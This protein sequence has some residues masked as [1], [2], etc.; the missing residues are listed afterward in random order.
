MIAHLKDLTTVRNMINEATANNKGAPYGAYLTTEFTGQEYKFVMVA[1][2]AGQ[3]HKLSS[4]CTT[5]ERL[6]AHWQ[7]FLQNLKD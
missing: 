1:R 3:V 4:A 2:S 7:G 5:Q 6:N